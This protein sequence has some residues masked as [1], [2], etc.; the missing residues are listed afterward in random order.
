MTDM[1]RNR[2]FSHHRS[3]SHTV[4]G[5]ESAPYLSIILYDRYYE[6]SWYSL[7]L[8]CVYVLFKDLSHHPLALPHLV[9]NRPPHDPREQ[10]MSSS[11]LNHV[12]I[13]SSLNQDGDRRGSAALASFC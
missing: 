7:S 8:S 4:M 1:E 3:S 2:A 13:R 9:A 11:I 12:K 10:V 5:V 6:I